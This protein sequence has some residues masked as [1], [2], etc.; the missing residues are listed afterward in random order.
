[1]SAQ[2]K[3]KHSSSRD[4][5]SISDSSLA[6]AQAQVLGTCH[7]CGEPHKPSGDQAPKACP[8]QFPHT[9]LPGS[10][11]REVGGPDTDGGG[12]R[13]PASDRFKWPGGQQVFYSS[14]FFLFLKIFIYL[15]IYL[16][17]L[18]RVLVVAYGIFIAACG[19]LVAAYMQDLVP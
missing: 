12:G 2:P 5:G 11:G 1:M 15:F 16:F 9:P 19:L 14:F 17:R 8:P 10:S 18:H 4:R 13:L 7:L 3:F 6:R